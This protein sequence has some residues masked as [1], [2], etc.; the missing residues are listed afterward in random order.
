MIPRYRN[1]HVTAWLDGRVI[2]RL[3]VYTINKRF[4]RWEYRDGN[5]RTWE[6]ADKITVS[7]EGNR[8]SR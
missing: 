5:W 4:A 8:C 7:P 6:R 1:W 3:T 2:D